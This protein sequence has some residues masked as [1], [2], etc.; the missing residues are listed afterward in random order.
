MKALAADLSARW[1]DLLWMDEGQDLVE[2][3]LMLGMVAT[4]AVV[5]SN[6]LS[7]LLTVIFAKITALISL[8][9][10]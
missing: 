4:L 3:G 7:S 5:F 9:T 2:Y 10:G 8:T 6:G 1:G